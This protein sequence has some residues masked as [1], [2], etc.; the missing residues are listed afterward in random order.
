MFAHPTLVPLLFTLAGPRVLAGMGLS[1]DRARWPGLLLGNSL[2][3][4]V[5]HSC[6]CFFKDLFVTESV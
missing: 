1:G 6:F 5:F 2:Q 3:V 4:A